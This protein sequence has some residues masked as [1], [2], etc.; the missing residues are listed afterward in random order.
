[1]HFSQTWHLHTA[2]GG[3][4]SKIGFLKTKIP[5]MCNK[6]HLNHLREVVTKSFGRVLRHLKKV[7]IRPLKK[8]KAKKPQTGQIKTIIP[9]NNFFLF[10][11]AILY[12]QPLM[13]ADFKLPALRE[14]SL[15]ADEALHVCKGFLGTVCV[16]HSS[17]HTAAS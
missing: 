11:T 5:V 2:L 7:K 17:E 3:K 1:M 13:A 4:K 16:A 8:I 9:F 6:N 14:I 15:S 10:R 12:V